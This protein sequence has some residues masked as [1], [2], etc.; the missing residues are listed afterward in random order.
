MACFSLKSNDHED[1]DPKFRLSWS[2]FRGSSGKKRRSVLPHS[3]SYGS[4]QGNRIPSPASSPSSQPAYPLPAKVE[5][6]VRTIEVLSSARD[7]TQISIMQDSVGITPEPRCFTFSELQAAC[8][9]FS[10]SNLVGEGGFGC[11]YRGF[12]KGANSRSPDSSKEVAVKMLNRNSQQGHKEWLAE[13]RFLG[14]VE[15]PNLVR[16]VGYCAEDGER[17]IQRLL[18]YEF[19]ARG[20]LEDH[21]FRKRQCVLSWKQRLQILHGAAQG[22]S[23]LHHGVKGI[24]VIFRDFKTSNVLLEEDFTPKLSDFGLARQ[25]PERGATHVSTSVVGTIGYAAPEYVQTG[26]LTSKSDVWS[27]GVVLF[28]MLT[29]RRSMDPN[30]PKSEQHLLEWVRPY[31]HSV[32]KVARIM[33][34]ALQEDYSLVE[35][36]KAVVLGLHCCQRAPKSRPTMRLVAKTLQAILDGKEFNP[37][38]EKTSP[39]RRENGEGDVN[40]KIRIPKA[41]SM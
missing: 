31:V 4:K 14:L 15:H 40:R 39:K 30:R 35:A 5:V 11:V 8:Q 24:Q 41:I 37:K 36:Q 19:I 32:N 1:G 34:P 18:V 6:D 2:F 20:S 3:G 27:F 9:G 12:L 13:V 26:H 22:L 25:G 17:G 7:T 29:G 33:D 16:L 28:E 38:S 21:L 10:Q 23:Y